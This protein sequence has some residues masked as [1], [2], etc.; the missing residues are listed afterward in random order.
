MKRKIKSKQKLKRNP[1]IVDYG[2]HLTS[3][4]Y[5]DSILEK[6][7]T[8]SNKDISFLYIRKAINYLIYDKLSPIY[9]LDIPDLKKI[10]KKL[11]TYFDE[12]KFDILLKVNVS[13]F[14]QLPDVYALIADYK[15]DI[16]PEPFIDEMRTGKYKLNTVIGRVSKEFQKYTNEDGDISIQEFIKNDDLATET[17]FFTETFCINEKIS[18]KYIEQII[19]I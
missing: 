15:F 5:L 11:K 1:Y 10:P 18:P 2:Y 14:N 3:S 16:F 6:G 7:L 4:K 19:N 8:P 9:F 13:S 17:I 12:S